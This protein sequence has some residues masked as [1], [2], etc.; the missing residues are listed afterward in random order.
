MK[1]S[2]ILRAFEKGKKYGW[3]ENEKT[4]HVRHA[5]SKDGCCLE[6]DY[7]PSINEF[8]VWQINTD[9]DDYEIDRAEISKLKDLKKVIEKW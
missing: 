4:R 3:K 8:I 9:A 1:L 2:T 7:N 6:A 5:I